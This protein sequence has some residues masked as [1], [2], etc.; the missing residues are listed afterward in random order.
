MS[1]WL[2]ILC[3]ALLITTQSA[4][5]ATVGQVVPQVTIRDANDNPASLPD[6]GKKVIALF[7]SDPD[8]A[9]I[10]DPFA[11]KLKQANLDL[12]VYRGI[13]VANLPDTY[14]P[15]SVIR[16]MVRKKIEKYDATI[17]TDVDST[18]AKAWGLGDLN[19]S[20]AVV[21]LDKKGVVRFQ[22]KGAMTAAEIE[23]T[24]QLVL[25]LMAE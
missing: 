5:A 18:L 3:C 25:K 6:Y 23:S 19:G 20:G 22:K 1:R 9:D 13:G 8:A 2:P 12:S 24:H 10:N 14:L 11:D 16:A 7:I 21:V 15:N 4:V 17:L